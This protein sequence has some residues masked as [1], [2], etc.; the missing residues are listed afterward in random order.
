MQSHTMCSAHL[1]TPGWHEL[2]LRRRLRRLSWELKHLSPCLFSLVLLFELFLG[3]LFLHITSK[4][5]ETNKHP[6]TG[7]H[8]SVSFPSLQPII[9][10]PRL[11]TGYLTDPTLNCVSA[12]PLHRP[13]SY[14]LGQAWVSAH[15]IF[16]EGQVLLIIQLFF[17]IF[18]FICSLTSSPACSP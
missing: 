14:F 12:E 16:G 10:P 2:P 5:T 15:Q 11:A 8:I 1:S 9:P 17:E 7:D 18:V 13:S 4:Q 6:S 3:N